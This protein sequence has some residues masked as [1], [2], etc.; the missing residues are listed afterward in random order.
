[1][2]KNKLYITMMG[3][4][5]VVGIYHLSTS[6]LEVDYT[7]D[8]MAATA[9]M[10][11]SAAC[12]DPTITSFQGSLAYTVTFSAPSAASG[13][14]ASAT[15][16]LSSGVNGEGNPTVAAAL[17]GSG[18]IAGKVITANPMPGGKLAGLQC[19]ASTGSMQ[20]KAN[21]D[22]TDN[23]NVDFYVGNL[24]DADNVITAGDRVDDAPSGTP[25]TLFGT[26]G[27]INT[28]KPVDGAATDF[29]TNNNGEIT[30]GGASEAATGSELKMLVDVTN[31][32]VTA[33]TD[34]ETLTITMAPE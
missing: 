28:T 10:A 22:G 34:T 13:A 4:F 24:A 1:M 18:G 14:T 21:G 16:V 20:L 12:T 2:I 3:V 5:L 7:P 8:A 15:A 32:N 27:Q 6:A 25:D 9:N 33:G 29:D 17:I 19:Q 11:P 23:T 30:F 31:Y 26:S